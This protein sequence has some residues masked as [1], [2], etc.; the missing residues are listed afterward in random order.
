MLS[1]LSVVFD[2]I[3]AHYPNQLHFP[4]TLVLSIA[5][6]SRE[7]FGVVFVGGLFAGG[8]R[9]R[10]LRVAPVQRLRTHREKYLAKRIVH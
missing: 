7:A 2:T 1:I 6:L 3:L 8:D 4:P 9:I 5:W 10:R